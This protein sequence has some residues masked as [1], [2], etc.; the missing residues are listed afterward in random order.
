MRKR[1]GLKRLDSLE[2]NWA[3]AERFL[4]RHP[5]RH[6]GTLVCKKAWVTLWS[7]FCTIFTSNLDAILVLFLSFRDKAGIA[8]SIHI[9]SQFHQ[10][11]PPIPK[12]QQPHP[13]ANFHESGTH[14]KCLEMW[15]GPWSTLQKIGPVSQDTGSSGLDFNEKVIWKKSL[16]DS[17]SRHRKQ[18]FTCFI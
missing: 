6:L 9:T 7:K 2:H 14:V 10:Q 15:C 5:V 11:H 8:V 4:H 16:L 12:F 13:R 1:R 3:R 18:D 17:G